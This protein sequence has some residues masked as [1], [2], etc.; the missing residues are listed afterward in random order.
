MGGSG[1]FFHGYTDM[2]KIKEMVEEARTKTKSESYETEVSEKLNELLVEFNNRDTD[3]IHSHLDTIKSLLEQDIDGTVELRFGGSVSK[4]TYVDG[5]SDIDCLVLLK[6]PQLASMSSQQVLQYF[7]EK[8]I[9]RLGKNGNVSIGNL[10][11]TIEYQDGTK[12]QLLPAIKI[13]SGFVIPATSGTQW[14]KI[15][16]PDKFA[17]RLTIV[18]QICNGKVVPAIKLVKAIIYKLLPKEQCLTGYHIESIAIEAFKS[19]SGPMTTKAITEHF[20]EKAKDLVKQNI[21]DRTGQSVN[22]DD[23]LGNEGSTLRIAISNSLDQI[24]RNIN[25]ANARA[26]ITAWLSMFEE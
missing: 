8:I 23:Y 7:Q 3:K 2:D 4:H 5:L 17:T 20:F 6:D 26:D 1:G 21:R 13:G 16:R 12:I 22:V 14:S 19:Y 10:A 24:S 15:I 11:V 18:N 9:Q 25:S